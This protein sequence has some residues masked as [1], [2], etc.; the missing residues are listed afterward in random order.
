M[1]APRESNINESEAFSAPVFLDERSAG[2]Q[3]RQAWTWSFLIWTGLWL[4][5][6]S[7]LLS[8]RAVTTELPY[9]IG[10]LFDF[11]VSALLT[12]PFLFIA[13]RCPIDRRRT[14]RCLVI[15]A[16]SLVFF[17][18]FDDALCQMTRLL[19]GQVWQDFPLLPLVGRKIFIYWVHTIFNYMQITAVGWAIHYQRESR[20]RA[21]RARELEASLA[22]ARL[23]ALALQLQPHFLFNTLNSIAALLRRNPDA[24]DR[25]IARLAELL[26]HSLETAERQEISLKEEL[27]ALDCYLEIE[28][29]RFADRLEVQR[30]IAVDALDA[31][32]PSLLLQP[33][34][35][36]AIRY[37]IARR[38][39][40]GHILI[41]ARREGERVTLAVCDDGPG[42]ASG[43]PSSTPA[44]AG[45]GLANTRARLLNLYGADHA[46]EIVD[47]PDCGTEVRMCFPYRCDREPSAPAGE[48]EMAVRETAA[49]DGVLALPAALRA[50]RGEA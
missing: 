7:P 4:L 41:R 34:V 18:A 33:I 30:D 43:A 25:M 21:L 44:R 45:I 39:T 26:R 1:S 15:L 22:K 20:L 17:A 35:E 19:A 29:M 47:R 13:W 14:W 38:T 37:G 46:V 9:L 27:E 50:P 32:V 8:Q 6:Y 31:L 49:V 10:Y 48:S 40:R 36:N 28:A 24:A 23:E 16:L 11:W 12:P 5:L 3:W 2:R 42:F